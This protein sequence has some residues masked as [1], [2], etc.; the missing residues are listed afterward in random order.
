MTFQ[1]QGEHTFTF[2]HIPK[3]AGTS[4]TEWFR[5][6][7][8]YPPNGYNMTKLCETKEHW[9]INEVKNVTNNLGFTFAV[10]RNPYDYAVSLY[11]HLIQKMP[12]VYP[13]LQWLKDVTFE[14]WITNIDEYPKTFIDPYKLSSNQVDWIDDSVH[15]MVYEN[16]KHDFEI[17][18]KMIGN[19]FDLPVRNS[20]NRKEYRHYYNDE[21]RNLV[22]KIYEKDIERL[23]CVF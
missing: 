12:V 22:S 6:F 19:S 2:I 16:L 15:V 20:S 10:L 5:L 8:S 11:H 17:V 21:T 9:G 18:Q 4:I 7:A 1:V 14:Q 3:T 23:K 13:E